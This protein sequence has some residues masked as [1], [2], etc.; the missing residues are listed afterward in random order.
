MQDAEDFFRDTAAVELEGRILGVGDASINLQTAV[1]A[2][3]R[4]DNR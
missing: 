4:L 1:T 3:S 2:L